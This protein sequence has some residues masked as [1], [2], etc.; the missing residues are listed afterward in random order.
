MLLGAWRQVGWLKANAPTSGSLS[1][2]VDLNSKNKFVDFECTSFAQSCKWSKGD[3]LGMLVDFEAGAMTCFLNGESLGVVF[4]EAAL[5]EQRQQQ[6]EQGGGSSAAALDAWGDG[7]WPAVLLDVGESVL[8]NLGQEPFKY[9]MPDN[10]LPAVQAVTFAPQE[11]RPAAA[12]GQRSSRG[13]VGGG[14]V[15][16]PPELSQLHIE[17]AVWEPVPSLMLAEARQEATD[18]GGALVCYVPSSLRLCVEVWT[19]DASQRSGGRGKADANGHGEADSGGT[20]AVLGEGAVVCTS[21]RPLLPGTWTYVAVHIDHSRLDIYLDGEH[22]SRQ[23]LPGPYCDNAWPLGVGKRP[24]H[25]P[26]STSGRVWVEDLRWFHP[27]EG[28][29]RYDAFSTAIEAKPRH[30]EIKERLSAALAPH[31][32]AILGLAVDTS[33]ADI[34][35]KALAVLRALLA[36]ERASSG[37]LDKQPESTI[38]TFIAMLLR[39]MAA[40]PATKPAT[41]AAAASSSDEDERSLACHVLATGVRSD[42]R[43]RLEAVKQDA[44]R[45][46]I[47]LEGTGLDFWAEVGLCHLY[48]SREEEMQLPNAE[49]LVYLSQPA[50]PFVSVSEQGTR[51]SVDSGYPLGMAQMARNLSCFVK[52]ARTV[53]ARL[54]D[55]GGGASSSGYV[56]NPTASSGSLA[57][58]TASASSL[59]P[60]QP[61]MGSTG[62]LPRSVSS[63]SSTADA[64]AAGQGQLAALS[65]AEEEML[66]RWCVRCYLFMTQPQLELKAVIESK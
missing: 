20:A 50:L 38:T 3:A 31:M 13:H 51:P 64:E 52:I 44:M 32:S 2:G 59:V 10:A 9:N 65:K 27:Q 66:V 1:F 42:W 37:L 33:E 8:F 5:K 12:G 40:A 53:A 45:S 41:T 16:T 17:K 30:L 11:G 14:V 57:S 60:L 24:L 46:L 25:F 47:R 22:D 34:R 6:Q 39:L 61:S 23:E 49:G 62:R 19:G 48:L 55:A 63:A 36:E 29:I 28:S 21:K 43:L 56:L 4:T 18:R 26:C 54:G 15:K 35:A 58:P 7:L